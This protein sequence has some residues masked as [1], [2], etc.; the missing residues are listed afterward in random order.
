MKIG[1]ELKLCISTLLTISWIAVELYIV[2]YIASNTLQEEE[3]GALFSII[4]SF[5][6]P[7]GSSLYVNFLEDKSIVFFQCSFDIIS[8][9]LSN[10]K[11]CKCFPKPID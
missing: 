1:W 7:P 4:D 2:Q 3:H 8:C 10:R 9:K 11:I 5:K 6:S